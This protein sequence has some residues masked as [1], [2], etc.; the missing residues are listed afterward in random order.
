MRCREKKRR[1][2]IKDR[3][4]KYRSKRAEEFSQARLADLN[5]SQRGLWME[6]ITCYRRKKK[7]TTGSHTFFDLCTEIIPYWL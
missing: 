2:E 5:S 1:M 7:K 4:E 6:V 3:I